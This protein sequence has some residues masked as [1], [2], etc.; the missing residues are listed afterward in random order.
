MS[1][2]YGYVRKSTLTGQLHLVH[3][4]GCGKENAAGFI[5]SGSCFWCGYEAK[6]SDVDIEIVEEPE[7]VRSAH[8]E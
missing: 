8:H 3:C 1:S 7:P 5:T 4:P 2:R 6:E